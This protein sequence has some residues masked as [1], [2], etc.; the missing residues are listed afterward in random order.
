MKRFSNIYWLIILAVSFILSGCGAVGMLAGGS[1]NSYREDYEISSQSPIDV[2]GKIDAIASETGF[3]V[4]SIGK[5]EGTASLQKGMSAASAGLIGVS[6][7]GSITFRGINTKTITVS[8][9]LIGNFDYGSKKNTDQLF[10][11]IA[12]IVKS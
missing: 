10:D 9:M 11:K 1:T 8:I 5:N 12:G 7:S 2:F 4:S 3:S 6:K